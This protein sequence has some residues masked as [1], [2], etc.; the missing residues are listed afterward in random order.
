MLGLVKDVIVHA[1]KGYSADGCGQ[2]AAAISFYVLLSLFPLVLFAVSFIGIV[3]PE[4]SIR[5]RVVD[6]VLDA[7]PLGQQGPNDVESALRDVSGIESDAVGFLGLA[8]LVW[9]ASGMFGSLRAA[10]QDVFNVPTSA[11]L[12][13]RKAADLAMVVGVSLLFFASLAFTAALRYAAETED[14]V[15]LIDELARGS[16]FLLAPVRVLLPLVVS[17]AA[18]Y[19]IYWL[20]PASG[21]R[22]R[23]DLALGAIVSAVLFEAVKHLFT[24]YLANFT[25][26]ALV[27]GPI[28]AII[29]FLFWVYLSAQILLFGAELAV[30]AE[31]ERQKRAQPRIIIPG[32]AVRQPWRRKALRDVRNAFLK[33]TPRRQRL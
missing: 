4:S 32:A 6:L 2:R 27:F 15:P 7:I 31:Q 22:R 33:R 28:G 25:N 16:S 10:L 17:F 26:Y 11:P 24:F 30:A 9:A 12:L 19:A 21:R 23:A 14:N 29:A 13:V 3:A 5:E 20:V 1:V 8:A 18:F